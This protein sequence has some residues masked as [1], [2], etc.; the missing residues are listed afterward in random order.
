MIRKLNA[1]TQ[2][3]LIRLLW[4]GGY[5]TAELADQ[6]GLHYVTVLE[7]VRELYK[8]GAVHIAAWGKDSRGRLTRPLYKLGPGRDAPKAKLTPAERQARA[9]A[10]RRERQH[11]AVLAGRGAYVHT[12]NGRLGFVSVP[13]G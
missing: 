8:E 1:M 12:A 11:L 13:A 4:D 2:A 7:Y 9:R 3:K 5:N 6:T 10:R